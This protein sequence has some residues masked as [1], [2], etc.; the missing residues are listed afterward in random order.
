MIT[1][2]SA[3]NSMVDSF[4]EE[5]GPLTEIEKA[6][7]CRSFLIQNGWTVS[8]LKEVLRNMENEDNGNT[9]YISG[10]LTNLGS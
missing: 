2:T 7:K 1:W 3:V 9:E 8:D 5:I 4:L 10:G 6:L